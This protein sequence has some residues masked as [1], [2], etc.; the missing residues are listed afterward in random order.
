MF[1]YLKGILADIDSDSCVIDVHDIGYNVIISG[2]TISNLPGIGEAVKIYTYTNVKE[3]TFQL[4]GF[5]F[6]IV[7]SLIS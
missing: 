3:D 4:F 5:I 6:Y 7:V 1:A 2:H